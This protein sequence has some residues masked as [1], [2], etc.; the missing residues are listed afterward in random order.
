MI[1]FSKLKLSDAMIKDVRISSDTV[2]VDY[3]DWQEKPHTLSF[4]NAIS[5]FVLSAHGKAL[6]HGQVE[7]D[8]EYLSECCAAAEEDST[9]KFA[10]FDFIDVW[11]ERKILRVVAESMSLL[12]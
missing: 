7:T 5:C 1:D 9:E 8:G 10:V 6:S 2:E 4:N 11:S 12:A 3:I